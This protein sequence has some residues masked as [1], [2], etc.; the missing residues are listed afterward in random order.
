MFTYSQFGSVKCNGGLN[1]M[2]NGT[3][4]DNYA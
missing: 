4:D 2:K 3:T 1:K